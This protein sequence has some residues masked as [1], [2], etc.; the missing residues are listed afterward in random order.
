MTEQGMKIAVCLK[1]VI[2]TGLNLGYGQV[3]EALLRK[4][5][6]FRLNPNDAQALAL[7]IKFKEAHSQTEIT[8][9]S[10]GPGRVETY[11]RDGLAAGADRAIRV[12]EEGL[13][14]LSPYQKSKIL[15]GALALAG[16]DLIL[17]GARSLDNASGL[18]GPLM[19]AWLDMPC[20]CETVAF[21]LEKDGMTVTRNFSKGIQE[22]LFCRLPAVLAV[23]GGQEK[24]PYAS[25]EKIMDSQAARIICYSLADIGVSP[26]ELKNDP[27]RI[28]G[29]SFPRP[30]PKAAPYD[31]S[32][33]AFYRILA[34]LEGGISRRRGEIL[35]GDTDALVNQLFELLMREGVVKDP[36]KQ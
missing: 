21:E 3:G 4:G 26:E 2:D 22:R 19:A 36:A 33:P 5:Q 31:A 35:K 11:L 34:L 13:A 24:L 18:V 17:A 10:L 20:I 1:E 9:V 7:A 14:D 32:L 15:S 8:V 12:W 16:F 28:S 6:S 27:T 23:A 30:R 25:L 29:F